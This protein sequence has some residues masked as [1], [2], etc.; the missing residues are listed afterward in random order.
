MDK[1]RIQSRGDDINEKKVVSINKNRAPIKNEQWCK[2][3][4]NRREVKKE[5]MA[6]VDKCGRKEMT[7]IIKKG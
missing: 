7:K 4:R 2:K 6:K 3:K 1:E 5:W